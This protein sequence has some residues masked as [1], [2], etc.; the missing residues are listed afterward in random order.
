MVGGEGEK[1]WEERGGE[2]ERE[3]EGGGGAGNGGGWW[4][5]GEVDERTEEISVG[6]D[7]LGE[8]VGSKG[9]RA[10]GKAKVREH[11]QVTRDVFEIILAAR[12]S[13]SADA[14]ER[15]ESESRREQ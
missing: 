11:L 1:E 9:L 3:R 14:E 4:K 7:V 12:I 13:T 8:N 6:L 2:G 5:V 10:P 15:L